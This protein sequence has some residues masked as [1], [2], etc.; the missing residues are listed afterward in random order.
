MACS[1]LLALF[2]IAIDVLDVD[3]CVVD[4]DADGQRESAE[5]HDVDGFAEGGEDDQRAEDGERDRN[6][7][8][9]RGAPASEEDQDHDGGEAGRDQSF[10]HHAVNRAANKDRLIRR[11]SRFLPEE[12]VALDVIEFFANILDDVERGGRA[13]L[14]DRHHDGALSVDADD[15]GLRRVAVADVGDVSNVDHGA[16]DDADGKIV[17]LIDDGGSRV[18]L[19]GVLEAV[20]LHG[21]GGNDQVLSR[22]GIHNV[23]RG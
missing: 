14:H 21:A 13:R 20:H 22:D 17:E 9:Q 1:N 4:Q 8:D 15:V 12:A 3:G 18:G 11:A 16:I 5:G 6:R 10:A 7:D 23:S 2:E 19:D